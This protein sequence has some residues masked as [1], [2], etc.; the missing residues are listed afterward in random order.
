MKI[1]GGEDG[2]QQIPRWQQV[3]PPRH[4]ACDQ[5]DR[6]PTQH[7]TGVRVCLNKGKFA[8]AGI[9]VSCV[10]VWWGDKI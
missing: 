9:F 10:G 5:Q 6:F 2:G 3:S 7:K 8:C 4:V 1:G